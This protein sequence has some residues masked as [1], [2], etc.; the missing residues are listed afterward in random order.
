MNGRAIKSCSVLA[1]QVQ[2]GEVTT[3]EGLATDGD[4]HPMQAA[5]RECHGLQCGFC[6]PGMVM[7]AVQLLN[8]NPQAERG[9]DPRGPRRQH[10]PLHGLPQHR[11]GDPV[12]PVGQD[13][14]RGLKEQSMGNMNEVPAGPIGQSLRRARGPAL[15]SPA[16][17][18]TPTTSSCRTRPTASSC[19]ARTR[20]R[21]SARSTSRRRRS[22]P[23]SSPS[24]PAPISPRRRSAGCRAAG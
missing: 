11:Q 10:L 13:A 22:R 5:F 21:G 7:S 12:L 23:A 18:A 24:S 17:A 20:T 3:I 8:D 6:T 9:G 4:L 19:A 16:P 15:S 14:D 1:A 2:G